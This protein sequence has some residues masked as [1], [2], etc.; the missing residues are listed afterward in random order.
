[1]KLRRPVVQ[2]ILDIVGVLSAIAV[3]LILFATFARW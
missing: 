1:M 3:M 2:L